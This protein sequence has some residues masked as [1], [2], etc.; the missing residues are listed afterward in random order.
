MEA[1]LMSQT[2]VS[3]KPVAVVDLSWAMYTFRHYY[4]DMCRFA[5]QGDAQVMFPIGHVYGVIKVVQE[6]AS[7]YK[8]VL[9][10]VDSRADFRFEVLPTYKSGRH[11]PTGDPFEDYKVMTDLLNI[12]KI[13]TFERN[14]FFIRH[15]GCEADDIIASLLNDSGE[16]GKDWSAYFNDNDILQVRGKYR[17][18]SSFHGPEVDRKAYIEKKYGLGL[19]FLPVWYKVIRGDASDKVPNII[20]RF[21]SKQLVRLCLDL[22]NESYLDPALSYMASMKVSS[23]FKWVTE[24]AGERGSVLR[25]AFKRNLLVVS[26]RII[27]VSKLSL[28]RAGAPVEEVQDLLS[29]YGIRDYVPGGVVGC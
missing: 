5:L 8:A 27:P 18:F 2:E 19:D 12:L 20:P 28:K 24:Q 22:A 25:E 1:F 17:W 21:P 6:L 15:E 13:T 16:G 29:Y 7:Q 9:L 11:Q 3:G 26:P 23:A 10:A 4:K 14:V